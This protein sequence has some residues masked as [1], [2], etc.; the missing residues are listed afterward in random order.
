MESQYPLINTIFIYKAQP[1]N[2]MLHLFVFERPIENH[3]CAMYFFLNL[4]LQYIVAFIFPWIDPNSFYQTLIKNLFF[5]TILY[6][7]I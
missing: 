1:S 6:Q 5:D 4:L 7:K 2:K 3:F